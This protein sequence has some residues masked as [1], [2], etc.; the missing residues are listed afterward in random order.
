MVEHYTAQLRNDLRSANY[1]IRVANIHP[2]PIITSFEASATVGERFN[3]NANPYPQ[4]DVDVRNWRKLR[5]SKVI[6]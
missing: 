6:N 2:G 1:N 3:G 4:M 5:Q